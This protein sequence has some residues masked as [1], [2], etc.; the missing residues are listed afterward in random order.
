M[1]R[2]EYCGRKQYYPGSLTRETDKNHEN[3]VNIIGVS[4]DIPTGHLKNATPKCYL[5]SQLVHFSIF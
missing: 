1:N 2:K 3:A 5:S 4:S